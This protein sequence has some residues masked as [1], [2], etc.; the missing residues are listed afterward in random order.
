MDVV[1]RERMANFLAAAIVTRMG[2]DGFAGSVAVAIE[3]DPARQKRAG[4]RP[5]ISNQHCPQQQQ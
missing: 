5:P 1:G 2:G 4:G 3:R